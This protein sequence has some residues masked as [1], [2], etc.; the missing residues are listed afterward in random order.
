MKLI[1]QAAVTIVLAACGDKSNAEFRAEVTAGIHAS[2]A[3]ELDNLVQATHDL[4]AAAPDHAW[5]AMAD[6]FAMAQMH[7]AWRRA[8]IA[9]EHVEGATAPLFP[10]LDLAMDARYNEYLERAGPDG[11][12]DLFDATGV[13]GMHAVER[14]LYSRRIRAGIIA[15]ESSLAGYVPAAY[16]ATEDEAVAF[17]TVLVQRLVDDATALRDRWQPTAIDIGAAYQGLVGLMNEQKLKISAAATGQE[18]S[19]YANL[20]LFDMRNNLSGTKGIYDSFRPWI[21]ARAMASDDAIEIRFRA[22]TILYGAPAGEALPTVPST[23]SSD[24]PTPDDLET[25]FGMLWQAVQDNVDPARADSIV[26]EMNRVAV[27]LGFP[28]FVA[29]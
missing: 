15:Y 11:D 4:Q 20:T 17:K 27:A 8:R 2:I 14:I 18:E 29:D 9:Y 19:R 23:W 12:P 26:A 16:P 21:Q 6:A 28:E 24:D 1:A 5:D 13:V 3:V 7:D 22:L 25:P 10:D